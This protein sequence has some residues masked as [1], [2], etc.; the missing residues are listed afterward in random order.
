MI[1]FIS[2]EELAVAQHRHDYLKGCR[3]WTS[4]PHAP[5]ARLHPCCMRPR[6]LRGLGMDPSGS[7]FEGLKGLHYIIGTSQLMVCVCSGYATVME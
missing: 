6:A 3:W 1:H 5:P 2:L 4:Q 7:A